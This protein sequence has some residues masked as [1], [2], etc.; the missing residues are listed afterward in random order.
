MPYDELLEDCRKKNFG[1]EL[2]LGSS[3]EKRAIIGFKI[4]YGNRFAIIYG[5]P[6]AE[7]VVG[8]LTVNYLLQ[9]LK[10][11]EDLLKKWSILLIPTVDPDGLELNKTWISRTFDP[12]LFIL[13]HYHRPD[14]KDIDWTFPIKTK[15]YRF[16]KPT[17]ETKILMKLIKE[18]RPLFYASLH[19]IHFAA[20]HFYATEFNEQLFND[21]ANYINQET[22]IPLQ[23]GETF[24][25]EKEWQY[26][27]GFYKFYGTRDQLEC[28]NDTEILKK[29]RRG[30][31]APVYYKDKVPNGFALVP[32]VPMLYSD[33]LI[34]TEKS[35]KTV[36]EV[37][38]KGN[39]ILLE[40]VEKVE[41]YWQMWKKYF[42]K[43]HHQYMKIKEIAT[44]WK[45]EILVEIRELHALKE[46][47]VAL[48][49]EVYS[50][51]TIVKYNNCLIF[52]QLY[53]LVDN[54]TKIPTS[55]KEKIKDEL[56]TEIRKIRNEVMKQGKIKIGKIN[57]LVRIQAF[58][59]IRAL[60]LQKGLRT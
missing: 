24:F 1:K 47:K 18:L 9:E 15:N 8:T 19:C 38:I 54:S 60:K 34:N 56:I 7:E 31:C 51:E 25:A 36:K 2:F 41:M 50:N 33:E 40:A 22:D 58:S 11:Q 29:L 10:Y 32:E 55:Q 44:S 17:K 20:A 21:I 39:E 45:D 28:I 48:K 4:G 23:K 14:N 37:K 46:K 43:K 52:G 59:L 3:E 35:N 6:H 27:D 5:Q 13:N 30:E 49:N 53:Q 12:E 42:N 26:R 16:N 57:D